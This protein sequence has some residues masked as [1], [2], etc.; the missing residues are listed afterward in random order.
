[1]QVQGCTDAWLTFSILCGKCGFV[2]F[3]SVIEGFITMCTALCVYQTLRFLLRSTAA[4][5]HPFPA[6]GSFLTPLCLSQCP[7][8]QS[9]WLYLLPQVC[10]SLCPG[11]S[12]LR[13]LSCAIW[14]IAFNNNMTSCLQWYFLHLENMI[15]EY[16]TLSPS[17]RIWNVKM[18]LLVCG[19]L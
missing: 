18:Y 14:I 10:S 15:S 7:A 16:M 19:H 1:M 6:L 2:V 17:A 3:V 9:T 5:S 4:L 13:R 12:H 11:Q 8:F